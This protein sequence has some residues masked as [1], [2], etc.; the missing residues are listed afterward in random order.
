[1]RGNEFIDGFLVL[2]I[3]RP[4]NRGRRGSKGDGE[5][6]SLGLGRLVGLLGGVALTPVIVEPGVD[7][8]QLRLSIPCGLERGS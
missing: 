2:G 1:M 3:A 4:Q 8:L 7:P 6:R 5:C